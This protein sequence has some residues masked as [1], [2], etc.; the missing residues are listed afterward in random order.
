[1]TV[2]WISHRGL[3][4]N[5]D[6][7]TLPA[8][9][10]AM[11]AG[12]DY[13]ETDLRATKDGHIILSHDQTLSRTGDIPIDVSASTRKELTRLNLKQ[14][15]NLLFFDEFMA[16]FSTLGH[17]FDIKPEN[18][19]AV[20]EL[21]SRCKI[22]FEKT[23][24]LLWDDAQQQ[25]LLRI[26]PQA[27]CFA[28]ERQCRRAGFSVLCKVPFLGGINPSTIYSVTPY[29]KGYQLLQPKVVDKYHQY[30][31]KVLAYLPETPAEAQMALDANVAFV[32]SNHDFKPKL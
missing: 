8:F 11:Q 17:V 18:G 16:T 6:E 26:F 2:K 12:F 22:D 23:I 32:L 28:T 20:I 15:A 9:D 19:F 27:N 5:A 10:A 29:F 30:G 7:N 4:Q 24:F 14:G 21:L 1:M 25:E 3:C 31:A 13:L